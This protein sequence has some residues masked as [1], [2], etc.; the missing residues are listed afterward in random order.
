[1]VNLFYKSTQARQSVYNKQRSKD[2]INQVKQKEKIRALNEQEE[3]N[4][5]VADRLSKVY[6]KFIEKEPVKKSI[7]AISNPSNTKVILEKLQGRKALPSVNQSLLQ[8]LGMTTAMNSPKTDEIREAEAMIPQYFLGDKVDETRPLVERAPIKTRGMI[9][10]KPQDQLTEDEKYEIGLRPATAIAPQTLS[11]IEETI[12]KLQDSERADRLL[13]QQ[14]I[15]NVYGRDMVYNR[16]RY[17]RARA[18]L[19]K[20]KKER[21]IRLQ[22][23]EQKNNLIRSNQIQN[24]A[25][26]LQQTRE[27]RQHLARELQNYLSTRQQ[28]QNIKE[29]LNASENV[30]DSLSPRSSESDIPILGDIDS[31]KLARS[32]ADDFIKAINSPELR[33]VINQMSV[34]KRNVD[35]Q[36]QRVISKYDQVIRDTEAKR[37]EILGEMQQVFE[38]PPRV[39]RQ[40]SQSSPTDTTASL[41]TNMT[42]DAKSPPRVHISRVRSAV[43]EY[44]DM[45]PNERKIRNLPSSSLRNLNAEL[46]R[47]QMKYDL[48]EKKN[49]INSMF[50][51]TDVVSH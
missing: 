11:T 13:R 9:T 6:A 14:A 40:R 33:S 49:K 1:M 4:E 17:T 3:Y 48:E 51:L 41:T 22:A 26:T 12:K 28:P 19:V 20:G 16:E 23:K 43:K 31:P 34:A 18:L 42:A 30:I 29:F 44:Y 38:S 15:R 35:R 47:L 21:G 24:Y 27:R 39:R 36:F 25:N 2:L 46:S 10:Y 50:R 37:D 45:Y 8:K 5:E 32:I 7:D